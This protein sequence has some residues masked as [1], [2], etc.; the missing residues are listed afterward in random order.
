MFWNR[1]AVLKLIQ[2]CRSILADAYRGRHF[3]K[4][5]HEVFDQLQ[6]V[7]DQVTGAVPVSARQ[8]AELIVRDFKTAVAGAGIDD[9]AWAA[10]T[11]WITDGIYVSLIELSTVTDGLRFA[12]QRLIEEWK[13]GD[14]GGAF[15]DLRSAYN[16]AIVAKDQ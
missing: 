14:V 10:L 8:S 9:D 12:A 3:V 13:G 1:V 4:L 5:S 16:A 2:I 15:L 7:T 11:D 6:S